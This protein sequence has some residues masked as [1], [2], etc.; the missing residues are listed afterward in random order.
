MPFSSKIVGGIECCVTSSVPSCTKR[1][2]SWFWNVL[3]MIWISFYSHRRGVYSMPNRLVTMIRQLQ[4]P[5]KRWRGRYGTNVLSNER[6][7]HSMY[8]ASGSGGWS[9]FASVPAALVALCSF[10]TMRRRSTLDYLETLKTI[11]SCQI[12][13]LAAHKQLYHALNG[14]LLSTNVRHIH[15]EV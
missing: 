15:Q 13:N 9:S 3:I 10:R 11:Y 1:K 8:C 12:T 7:R 5:V 2:T 4:W 14:K 6:M